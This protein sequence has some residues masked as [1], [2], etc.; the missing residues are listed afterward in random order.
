MSCNLFSD[1]AISPINQPKSISKPTFN[2]SGNINIH[3]SISTGATLQGDYYWAG[4]P[5]MST[6]LTTPAT[7]KRTQVPPPSSHRIPH[8]CELPHRNTWH[9]SPHTKRYN[10]HCI[11]QDINASLH[12]VAENISNQELA[13]SKIHMSCCAFNWNGHGE[14]VMCALGQ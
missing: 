4:Q 10:W 2:V 14:M 9:L 12:N 11:T 1:H 6:T 8:S 13:F 7:R 5:S 3:I